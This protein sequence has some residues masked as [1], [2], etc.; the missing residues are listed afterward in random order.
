KTLYAHS[1]YSHNNLK[2]D[3]FIVIA[4]DGFFSILNNANLTQAPKLSAAFNSTHGLAK[5]DRK[6]LDQILLDRYPYNSLNLEPLSK[7][8]DIRANY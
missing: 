2:S 7:I 5:F 3:R 4:D 6:A 8:I 1:Y